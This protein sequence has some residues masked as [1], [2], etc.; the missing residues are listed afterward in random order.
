MATKRQPLDGEESPYLP[1]GEMK[2]FEC[3]MCTTEFEVCLEPKYKDW[4]GP[5]GSTL[6]EPQTV[7]YCPFCGRD[8]VTSL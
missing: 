4:R 7:L 5:P 1:P 8:K 6:P 3:E 2:R